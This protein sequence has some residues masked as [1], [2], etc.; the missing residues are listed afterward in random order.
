MTRARLEIDLV[1]DVACPWCAIGLRSLEIALDRVSGLVEAEVRIRPFE[2]NPDMPAG[3]ED[4]REHVARKY[5]VSADSARAGGAALRDQAGAVGLDLAKGENRRI[6]N[7]FDAHRLLA[8]AADHGRQRALADGLFR[9]HFERG[10][11]LADHDVLADIAAKAGLDHAAARG[12]LGS[13]DYSDAVRAE[14]RRWLAEGVR[15]VPYTVV[16][17]R[18]VINGGQPPEKFERA[19]RHIAAETRA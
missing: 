5:G 9:A 6:W 8:W 17:D 18:Y 19:L 10:A 13:A 16:N 15:G 2:L 3:G 12:V 1:L 14:E 11:S 7:T 4:V